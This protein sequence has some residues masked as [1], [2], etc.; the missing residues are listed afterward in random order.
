MQVEF[1]P[2]F[3]QKSLRAY[4]ESKG[5]LMCAY[6]SLGAPGAAYGSG[7]VMSHPIITEIAQKMGKTPAQ[8]RTC[9]MENF[10][11]SQQPRCQFLLLRA[12]PQIHT[13]SAPFRLPHLQNKYL[14]M[15]CSLRHVFRTSFVCWR[16]LS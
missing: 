11:I 4:C 12:A 3:Q 8:V 15:D 10:H 7:D 14:H 9:Y 6:T 16:V 5:I 13:N 2:L 1:H